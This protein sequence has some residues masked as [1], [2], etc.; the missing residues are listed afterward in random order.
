[1]T[2]FGFSHPKYPPVKPHSVSLLTSYGVEPDRLLP[3]GV[4]LVCNEDIYYH[5]GD[6]P[7]LLLRAGQEVDEALIPKLINFGVTPN[8]FRIE[9]NENPVYGINPMS[10]PIT[11]KVFGSKHQE[12]IVIMDPDERSSKRLS[13]CLKACGIPSDNIQPVL[14]PDNLHWT[15]QKYEPTILFMDFVLDPSHPGLGTIL[16]PLRDLSS[17]Q[18]IIFTV[19][20][21]PEKKRLRQQITDLAASNQTS[22]L[23]KPI[24]RFVLNNLLTLRS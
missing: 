6:R 4:A 17:L 5:N 21:P 1:M 11:S 24:N 20:L 19:D 9:G 3:E 22:V 23:F 16:K 15:L 7:I 8:Q 10:N 13:D 12:K 18:K 2:D 14:I